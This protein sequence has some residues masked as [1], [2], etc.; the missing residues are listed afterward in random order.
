MRNSTLV[1]AAICGVAL[2]GLSAPAYAGEVT[3]NGDPITMHA[4]SSCAFSGLDDHL[5]SPPFSGVTVPGEVQNFGHSKGTSEVVSAPRG[6]SDVIIDIGFGPMP[7][8]C[9]AHLHGMKN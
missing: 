6:A 5:P 8:G 7:A 1:G 2:F 4:N 9:N 3:G